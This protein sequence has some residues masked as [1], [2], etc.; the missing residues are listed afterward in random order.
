MAARDAPT[1]ML[2]HNQLGRR[3]I[4][5]CCRCELAERLA[6][7]F[8]FGLRM[9]RGVDLGRLEQRFGLELP[10]EKKEVLESFIEMNLLEEHDDFIRA[11]SRGR[12]LLDELA[13][14]II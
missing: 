12:L 2:T 6:E 14:R 11:T 13:A 1:P 7:A 10:F 3:N 8:C 4:T 9:N 5:L